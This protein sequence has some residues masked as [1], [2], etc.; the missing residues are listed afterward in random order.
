MFLILCLQ[1]QKPM[2]H[3]T[4]RMD[5]QNLV[6]SCLVKHLYAGQT[7]EKEVFNTE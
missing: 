2:N 3:M 7:H 6:S 1:H 4:Y 5:I